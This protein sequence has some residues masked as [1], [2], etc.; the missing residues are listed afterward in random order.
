MGATALTAL[1]T[2][3]TLTPST[4][5]DPHLLVSGHSY[6]FQIQGRLGYPLATSRD[7]RKISYPF[8]NSATY[9]A[10]FSVAD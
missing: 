3:M 4:A 9:S 2:Y 6:I 8:G 10:I 7:Y 5:I 1:R